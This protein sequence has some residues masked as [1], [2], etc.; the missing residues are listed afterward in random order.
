VVFFRQTGGQHFNGA[1]LPDDDTTIYVNTEAT[2][3]HHLVVAGHEV[4]HLMRRDAPDLYEGLQKRLAASLTGGNLAKFSR[5]YNP[6]DTEQQ[7]Y[8]RLRDAKQL[9]KLTEEFIADLIGN[10]AG[11]YKTWQTVFASAKGQDNPG[12]IQRVG[13]FLIDFIDSLL[14]RTNFQKFATDKMVKDLTKARADIRNTLKEYA[15]RQNQPVDLKAAVDQVKAKQGAP[16]GLQERQGQ[17]GAV[18]SAARAQTETP[19]F[20][21]WF[22]ESKVVDDQGQPLVVYHGTKTDISAFDGAK[23]GTA[24]NLLFGPGFYFSAFPGY[25]SEYAMTR[26]WDDNAPKGSKYAPVVKGG[27]NVVPAYLSVENPFIFDGTKPTGSNLTPQEIAAKAKADGHDGI[28][29]KGMLGEMQEI[30]AFRPEQVKSAT[31]NSG[32]FSADDPDITKSTDRRAAL[33]LLTP[34]RI[35]QEIGDLFASQR[36]F[37]WFHRTLGTQ[38]HKATVNP[39]FKKTF[40]AVQRHIGAVNTYANEA[41]DL[42]PTIF[43]KI[44]TLRDIAKPRASDADQAKVA[45]ALFDG[46]LADPD[47]AKGKIWTDAEL[48]DKYQMTPPQI[49]LYRQSRAAIDKSLD[50]LGKAEMLKEAGG[51]LKDQVMAAPTVADARVILAGAG[52]KKEE[53]DAVTEKAQRIEELKAGGYAPLM[54][55]GRYSVYVTDDTG[56]QVSFQLFDRERDATKAARELAAPGLTVRQGVLPQEVYELFA[57]ISPDTLEVFAD[58]ADIPKNAATQAFLKLARNQRSASKRLIRRKGTAGFS[59]DLTR[60]LA[61]FIT[62][63]ARATATALENKA[64]L[65]AVQNAKDNAPGDVAD[66]AANLVK[67][68]NNPFDPSAKIRGL[69]FVQ[70]LGGSIASAMVNMTQPFMMTFPYLSQH[71]GTAGSAKHLLAAVKSVAARSPM[72]PALAGAVKK[73]QKD[74]HISPQEIH[75]LIGEANPGFGGSHTARRILFGWGRLFSLAEE[76]N[77]KTTFVAAYKGA[78]EKK[79]ANPYDFAIQAVEAT[80]G[81]YNKGNRPN[82]ARNP[83]GA[84]ILTFKQYSIAYGE[85]LIRLPKKERLLALGM[86]MLM[87][88]AEGLPFG[89]DLDDVIDT[90]LQSLGINKQSK[91]YRQ[92]ALEG[93]LGKDAS[94]FVLKGISGTGLPIDVSR[95]LGMS[96]LIPGSAILLKGRGDKS[97]DVAEILGVSGSAAQDLFKGM[98]MALSGDPIKGLMQ[99]APKAFKD[100]D[101]ALTM[102]E[103]GYYPDTRGRK[104]VE[105]SPS[106]ALW[107]AVGF[108]PAVVAQES[109]IRRTRENRIAFAK[110]TES[111]I[112]EDWAKGI[113]DKDPEAVAA[114]QQEVRDWNLRNPGSPMVITSRQIATRVKNAQMDASQRQLKRTPK[115]MRTSL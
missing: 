28:F 46:T 111:R 41:A 14:A 64:M 101:K 23:G 49:R 91:E 38:F 37:N 69:M 114:A 95:R 67:A 30:I 16:D 73:A 55:F 89:E 104:Q 93:L 108:Q 11:E 62:S 68:V 39:A 87:A 32:A 6:G 54:R 7:T 100:V 115:E 97:R 83:L 57:G 36:G 45:T 1:V 9:D 105:T 27:E 3:A 99:V 33:E 20:K 71:L 70:Y 26:E 113:I 103:K 80:Q 19:E 79:I 75:H 42:V 59:E 81:I 61:S 60:V 72:E 92:Q 52:L 22:G 109:E 102:T 63:N 25:S 24:N 47:P 15:K 96:N 78:V 35:S 106:D 8:A 17:E 82:W 43:P 65:E 4:A 18:K 40:D 51:V 66:E 44:E 98:G 76:F 5:Y 2:D 53:M 110:E 34:T 21:R 48:V 13:K 88:G 29:I 107:K 84:T 10:R 56:E 112:A 90:I 77:R 74:G 12:L 94:E 50:D 31:G 86:L 58:A 85:F